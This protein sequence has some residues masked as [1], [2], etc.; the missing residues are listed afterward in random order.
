MMRTGKK[1]SLVLQMVELQRL[2]GQENTNCEFFQ[3]KKVYPLLKYMK[4]TPLP[5]CCLSQAWL[6]G[7]V[8]AVSAPWGPAP[9]ES[10]DR[11]NVPCGDCGNPAGV[12][13]VLGDLCM[14]VS[15][16]E[17]LLSTK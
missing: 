15:E 8:R 17:T 4:D 6:T 11:L 5:L 14:C 9:A 1:P 7:L 16:T 3:L 13:R 2:G 10:E 12:H